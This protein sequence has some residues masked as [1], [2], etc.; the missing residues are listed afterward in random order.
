MPEDQSSEVLELSDRVIAEASS[1]VTFVTLD[2]E[3]D[4]GAD[5]HVDV[6]GSISDTC[7]KWRAKDWCFF[8]ELHNLSFLCRRWSENNNALNL[9]QY[10][11]KQLNSMQ[12]FKYIR[13]TS[14]FNRQAF[15]RIPPQWLPSGELPYQLR[16]EVKFLL[17][18]IIIFGDVYVW[19]ARCRFW[20]WRGRSERCWALVFE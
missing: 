8:N 4:M 10:L 13:Q 7:G 14:T 2:T 19:F 11:R 20:D 12:I 15:G 17:F 9:I 6:V 5:D 3:P 1:C 16:M 18:A